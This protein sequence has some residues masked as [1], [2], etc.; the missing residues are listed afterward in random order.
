MM[1]VLNHH[2]KVAYRMAVIVSCKSPTCVPMGR[3]LLR[4]GTDPGGG[5][6]AS[7]GGALGVQQVSE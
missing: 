2:R 6:R 1:P 7:L 5:G 4:P 3:L